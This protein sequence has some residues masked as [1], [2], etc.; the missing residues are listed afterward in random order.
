MR[1]RHAEQI[2]ITIQCRG[3]VVELYSTHDDIKKKLSA[4]TIVEITLGQWERFGTRI[5]HLNIQGW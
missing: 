1:Q 3:E 4:F 2:N 5:A